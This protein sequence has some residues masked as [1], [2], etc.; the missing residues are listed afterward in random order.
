M[1]VSRF[2]QIA[3]RAAKCNAGRSLCQRVKDRQNSLYS[4]VNCNATPRNTAINCQFLKDVGT[5]YD[6]CEISQKTRDRSDKRS[7]SLELGRSERSES[8]RF[9]RKKL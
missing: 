9:F 6:N 2:T 4:Q 7:L 1:L 3:R 8:E 5:F